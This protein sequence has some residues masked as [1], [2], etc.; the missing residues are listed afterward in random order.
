VNQIYSVAIILIT[1][2]LTACDPGEG[3]GAT[4]D[5]YTLYRTS[6]VDSALRIHVATFDSIE[7]YDI[8]GYNQENCEYA[9]EAFSE[10]EDFTQAGIK[11]FC[12]KGLYRK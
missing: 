6:P 8:V 10:R 5:A 12:E 11:Y 2:T 9:R 1:I 3:R 4:D 7:G